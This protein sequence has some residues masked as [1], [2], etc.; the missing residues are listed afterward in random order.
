MAATTPELVHATAISVA[1]RAALIRGPSGAGKSDLALRCLA[2]GPGLLVPHQAQLVSDDQVLIERRGDRLF[3]RPPVTIAGK[4]EVRGLGILPMPATLQANAE[5]VLA[6]DLVPPG[7]V[8][9]L[10]D[11]WPVTT[12]LGV[13][14]P[15][16]RLD[17]GVP[18]AAITLLLAL[19]SPVL[20]P[21]S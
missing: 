1:G 9:R 19:S 20:P 6:V 10:P 15:L 21:Q 17:P 3:A 2:C 12:V 7:T 18:S 4:L 13:S 5:V 11:P 16:I 8:Q 14:L